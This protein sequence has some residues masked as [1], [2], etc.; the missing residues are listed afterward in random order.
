M[1]HLAWCGF[2]VEKVRVRCLRL[3]G[4]CRSAFQ[5]HEA[6][7][8][9]VTTASVLYHYLAVHFL[10]LASRVEAPRCLVASRCR[11]GAARWLATLSPDAASDVCAARRSLCRQCLCRAPLVMP[12]DVPVSA[13]WSGSAFTNNT[14][15]IISRCFCS[16][17]EYIVYDME[18]TRASISIA[19]CVTKNQGFYRK[20]FPI[21]EGYGIIFR[22]VG[23]RFQK[24]SEIDSIT[25]IIIYSHF[26]NGG[27][28][29]TSARLN[30]QVGNIYI[31]DRADE[32]IWKRGLQN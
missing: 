16:S 20:N 23:L 7:L 9:S 2:R 13:W 8:L 5:S 18:W 24:I 22:H 11:C 29:F 30:S 3:T 19:T 17:T 12:V 15:V 14:H 28:F 31:T 1:Y 10:Q 25:I 21:C 26:Q 4:L 27:N 6:L 32:I